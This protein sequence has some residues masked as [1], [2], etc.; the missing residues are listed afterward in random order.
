MFKGYKNKGTKV[1]AA[2]L[3]CCAAAIIALLSKDFLSMREP[4]VIYKGPGVTEI[5]M[6]S[7]YY[8]GIKGTAGDTEVYV[9]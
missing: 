2:L 7:D 8:P 9:L 4:E 6:L 3:L 1:T 5:K